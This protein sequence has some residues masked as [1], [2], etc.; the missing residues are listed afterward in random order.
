MERILVLSEDRSVGSFEGQS[1]TAYRLI[2]LQKFTAD[3]G[4]QG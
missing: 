2:S 4:G 1:K 3:S